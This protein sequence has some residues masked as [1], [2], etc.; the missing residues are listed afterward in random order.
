MR[1]PQKKAGLAGQLRRLSAADGREMADQRTRDGHRSSARQ[2]ADEVIAEQITKG[3]EFG[4]MTKLRS[5]ARAAPCFIVAVPHVAQTSVGSQRAAREGPARNAAERA[6]TPARTKGL[7]FE[8]SPVSRRPLTGL[9]YQ[10]HGSELREC[11]RLCTNTPC[12]SL[13]MLR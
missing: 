6:R 3:D 11:D 7:F 10:L 1:C 4:K 5:I 8:K 9:N 13:P 2:T 12:T